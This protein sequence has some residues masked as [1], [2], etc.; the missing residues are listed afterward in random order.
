MGE[1]RKHSPGRHY[2]IRVF[3]DGVEV[4]NVSAIEYE[5][6]SAY[7]DDDKILV[8]AMVKTLGEKEGQVIESYVVSR[9]DSDS[10]C[11]AR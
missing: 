11:L 3:I 1:Y 5:E 2:S 6:K 7:G 9:E 4:P 10:K 8:T